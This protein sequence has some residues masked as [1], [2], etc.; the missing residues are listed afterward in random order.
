MS[1]A[2][3]L[4]SPALSLLLLQLLALT[5]SC[6]PVAGQTPLVTLSK[7][8]KQE[9][10][11]AHNV[12]RARIA[13]GEIA[14]QPSAADMTLLE[15]DDRL[16]EKA[17]TWAAKC[18]SGHD[19]K[20]ERL[21]PGHTWVGQNWAGSSF[22]NLT[23]LACLWFDEVKDYTY[24]D[25]SKGT[26]NPDQLCGHYTQ[27]IWAQSLQLGCAVA[28]CPSFSRILVCNYATGGNVGNLPPYT[29]GPPA[30]Q[31]PAEY[32]FTQPGLGVCLRKDQCPAGDQCR[33]AITC[34]NG[35][36]V[37]TAAC[38]CTC[39]LDF[40][41][42]RCELPCNDPEEFRENCVSDANACKSFP[43]FCPRTCRRCTAA[44]DLRDTNVVNRDG[45][46]ARVPSNK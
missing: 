30:S 46:L 11:D 19:T 33:C 44:T 40:Y 22:N 43:D 7:A 27:F 17:A 34:Q 35:G 15:W 6:G 29:R 45:V 28:S 36:K 37:D 39:T 38:K 23:S 41:G 10:L 12:L 20:E 31:C 2:I 13:R 3:V 4:S 14:G 21:I 42:A 8:D 16:M 24:V 9:I 26:C 1:P 25:K 5:L 18:T 32:G